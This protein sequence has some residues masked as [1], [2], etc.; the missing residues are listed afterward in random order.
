MLFRR[1]KDSH[2]PKAAR[3]ELERQARE[4]LGSEAKLDGKTDREIKAMVVAK[5]FPALKV[6]GA[7]DPYLGQ[8][9]TSVVGVVREDA[10]QRAAAERRAAGPRAGGENIEA[11]R[12]KT[13]QARLRARS[14]A[15]AAYR[16][17]AHGAT[18]R[19]AR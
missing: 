12:A 2:E 7:S 16:S 6:D 4:V 15:E 13:E 14:D 18:G 19:L 9:F 3:A 10:A 8:A 17:P 11:L 1:D 5:R